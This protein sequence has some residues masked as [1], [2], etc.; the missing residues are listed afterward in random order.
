MESEAAW[1]DFLTRELPESQHFTFRPVLAPVTEFTGTAPVPVQSWYDP[2]ALTGINGPFD[3]GLVDGPVADPLPWRYNRWPAAQFAS[4]MLADACA[5][6]LDDTHRMGERNSVAEWQR[7][8]GPG[9]IR[10]RRAG[11]ATWLTRGPARY[12]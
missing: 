7:A 12:V 6:L 8:M 2:G 5:V 3:M 1:L 4:G 10:R 11:S 9:P